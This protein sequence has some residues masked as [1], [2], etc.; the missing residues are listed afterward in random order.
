MKNLLHYTKAQQFLSFVIL[1]LCFCS[2]RNNQST[3][4]DSLIE[5]G[6][7]DAFE[8]ATLAKA[9]NGFVD[10]LKL[11]GFVNDSNIHI[12]FLNAQ[13]DIPMLT[14]ACQSMLNGNVKL[15]ATNS[16]MATIAAVKQTKDIPVFM[17]VAPRPDIA[18]LINSDGKSPA[19]LF[20]VY[21]TLFYIDSSI[22]IIHQLKPELKR[23]GLIYNQ[24]ETQSQDAFEVVKKA[25]ANNNFEL[26]SLPVNSSADS[27]IV[28]EALLAKGIDVFFALPDNVIFSS[29]ETIAK[30]CEKANV[31]IFTSEAGLV[32]RG[33]VASYGADFYHWGFQS[34]EQA[35]KF[36]KTNTTNNL[37]PEEV[38]L[39]IRVIS[40]QKA[41]QYGIT[42]PAA[43]EV[44]DNDSKGNN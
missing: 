43:F 31:P 30:S 4:K 33:A 21:E 5:I 40:K 13:G 32:S 1:A 3:K 22:S 34:G 25:C 24:A 14:Q 17:M 39:R 28:T 36:L 11:N 37:Q 35:A 6:F 20:G 18:G 2:C 15:I 12:K 26:L 27:K 10:A 8:D 38:K 9:R 23:L 29:F 7:I 19:N 42:I 41:E 44:I 16:T